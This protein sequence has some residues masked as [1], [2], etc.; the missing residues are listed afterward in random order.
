MNP[1][2]SNDGPMD[3]ATVPDIDELIADGLRQAT[4]ATF[5][6][7]AADLAVSLQARRRSATLRGRRP[8]W[9]LAVGAAAACLV[10]VLAGVV[11]WTADDGDLDVVANIPDDPGDGFGDYPPGWHEID[12][13][14]VPP[15]SGASLAWTG[16]ELVVVGTARGDEAATAYLYDIARRSWTRLPDTG[17]ADAAVVAAADTLVLVGVPAGV[18]GEGP[19]SVTWKTRRAGEDSWVDHGA[20]ELAPELV[21]LGALGP[22]EPSGH[23]T[24]LWTGERVID[25]THGSVLDPRDGTSTPLQMPEDPVSHTNL[26]T[27][28]PVWTGAEV[29]AASW[30]EEAGLAWDSAGTSMREVPGLPA[31]AGSSPG[32]TA[33]SLAVA[34]DGRVY[35][36]ERSAPASGRAAVLD[37]GTGTWE[38]LPEVPVSPDG[39][40]CPSVA[41]VV[42]PELLV[43]PCAPMGG[44]SATPDSG[45][46]PW[47]LVGNSW[48]PVEPVPWNA[49]CCVQSWLGTDDALVAWDTDIDT[50]NN[51]E[52]P[53]VR[54]ALWVPGVDGPG[55]DTAAGAP[56]T[57]SPT[58][59]PATEARPLPLIAGAG[60]CALGELPDLT[61]VMPAV[62]DTGPLPGIGGTNIEHVC[63]R[64][65]GSSVDAG[66]HV[67]QVAGELLYGIEPSES[68]VNLEW[69]PFNEGF[70]VHYAGDPE[71]SLA[72]Y[73]LDEEGFRELLEGV[74]AGL[75]VPLPGG[76]G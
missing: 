67:T 6:T 10:A 74:A 30:S 37:P 45:V 57:G 41:A 35:L 70:G 68:S 14:P 71:W 33:D 76:G 46:T 39:A 34:R 55:P 48:V 31:S 11:V 29:V 4:R 54:A 7:D 5:H 47:R 26:L 61:P 49:S 27:S 50:T 75:E 16:T 15:M 60:P 38:A 64:Y 17:L 36:F 65:W 22:S 32:F 44:V 58:T 3:E 62:L 2:S 66:I 73:G 9:V 8:G 53:Y 23:A 63:A 18:T 25:T 12:P 69:G 42:G 56:T 40:H 51:P 20:V 21:S 72:V 52:A 28:N 59:Q 13:G 1:E 19:R 24:L 43:G